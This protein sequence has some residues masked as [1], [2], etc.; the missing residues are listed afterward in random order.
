MGILNMAKTIK[1]RILIWAILLILFVG[2]VGALYVYYTFVAPPIK[3]AYLITRSGTVYLNDNL[4]TSN[5][6]LRVGDRIKTEE[7][8]AT[9]V[10]GESVFATIDSDSLVRIVKATHEEASIYIEYGAVW[11]YVTQISRS[12]KYTV[13]TNE[14]STTATG[15]RFF[16]SADDKFMTVTQGE[17]IVTDSDQEVVAREQTVQSAQGVLMLL[18]DMQ[19]NEHFLAADVSLLKELREKEIDKLW[20]VKDYLK[21]SYNLSDSE[22]ELYLT[23]IDSGEIDVEELMSQS[24]FELAQFEKIKEITNELKSLS[25]ASN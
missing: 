17:V 19:M 12:L 6:L 23:K 4:V 25:T 18:P 22:I 13:V 5:A 24:P 15:T 3:D 16:V 1:K 2:S 21:N 7:G 14:F 11:N 10:L 8:T 20:F 9:I